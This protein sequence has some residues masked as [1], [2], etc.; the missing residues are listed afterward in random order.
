MTRDISIRER[1]PNDAAW[2]LG[3]SCTAHTIVSLL[4]QE[5]GADAHAYWRAWQGPMYTTGPGTVD[6]YLYSPAFAQ[7]IWPLAQLP[8]PA[9]ATI[10]I[11]G[12]G[13]LLAWLLRPL[14]WR[15]AVPLW[16]AGLPEITTGNI[17]IVMAAVAVL[18]FRHPAAWA[19]PALTKIAPAVG[20][21]WFLV[22]REWH[23]LLT[24]VIATVAVALASF[25][26][27]PELWGQWFTFL[28]NH[29]AES[30]G[31]IGTPLLPPAVWRIPVGVALV[32]WGAA[33]NR[34]WTVP[35]AMLLC[36]PVLWLGSFALLAAIPRL[37]VS[38]GQTALPRLLESQP[39]QA[40]T[41]GWLTLARRTG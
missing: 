28:A 19:L 41:P 18:G 13:L 38:Q 26:L 3:I 30:T 1:L 20:P 17:F 4:Y 36:T 39:G 34:R 2:I 22:R 32:V 8:W 29:L 23:A 9:F 5:V 21:I 16:L 37:R 14:T 40:S 27:S 6:A 12:L 25:A 24:T 33:G 11:L 7:V 35:V 31:P 15:W 10:V